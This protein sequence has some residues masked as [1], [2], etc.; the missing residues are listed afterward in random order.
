M[1]ETAAHLV[2]RVFP[3]DVPVRQWVLTLPWRLRLS[4]AY[5]HDL[6]LA[7]LRAYLGTLF[8]W[9][10]QRAGRL[11]MQGARCGAVTYVQR[12]AGD[13]RLNPH[14]HSLLVD[15]VFT[16]EPDEAPVFHELPPPTDAEVADLV[17]E[18]SRRVGLLLDERGLS[19]ADGLGEAFQELLWEEPALASLGAA[20]AQGTVA[21]GPM[22]GFPQPRVRVEG[23]SPTA[24][25]KGRRCAE[26][27]GYNLHANVSIKAGDRERLERVCRYIARPPLSNSRLTQLDDGRVALQ[28]RHMFSDG[29][30]HVVFEPHEL[31]A[32]LC[33]L[34]PRPWKNAL[35]YAGVF[36]G[37]CKWRA[38]IV[39]TP[40]ADESNAPRRKSAGGGR[41]PWADL[42]WR[43]FRIDATRCPCGGTFEPIAEIHDPDVIVA[44]LDCL[45]L[46]STP[47]PIAPARPPPDED[48]KV[49]WA[50]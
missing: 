46:P 30:T 19:D 44:I 39:P 14:F 13:L 3:H 31:L 7:V 9:Y 8:E 45:G 28:L 10:E 49:G 5:D 4:V 25:P 1:A 26:A 24:R 11:G 15:G 20:A 43:V 32:R 35:H 37:N 38:A 21:L 50:A 40:P 36:A 27:E 18:V 33:A 16:R 22:Q 41:I 2:D 12:F 34:V 47:K 48:E 17:A 6:E 29:S 42:L 23:F